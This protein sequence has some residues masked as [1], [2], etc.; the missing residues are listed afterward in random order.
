MRRLERI[1]AILL[2][3]ILMGAAL[4]VPESRVFADAQQSAPQNFDVSQ[5][6]GIYD[7]GHDPDEGYYVGLCWEPP[8][9]WSEVPDTSN[10]YSVWTS[11]D[12]VNYSWCLDVPGNQTSVRIYEHG[13][14]KLE[15][16][17]IYY[18]YVTAKHIHRDPVTGEETTNESGPSNI[19]LF[20]TKLDIEAA[21]SAPDSITIKWN[22]VFLGTSRIDYDIYISE[23]KD[24]NQTVP[25]NV[26]QDNIG[27]DKPVK[28]VQG[29]NKLM[30][31]RSGLRGGTIY[32]I[33]IKP[34]VSD[35]RVR[36]LDETEIVCGSTYIVARILRISDEF[37]RIEWNPVTNAVMGEGE[38]VSY[39]I[40]R[41]D[42]SQ[43]E[44]PI[45]DTLGQTRD[46]KIP[47]RVTR[48]S[49]YYRIV[50]HV[51]TQTGTV[52]EVKSDRILAVESEIPAVPPVPDL[53]DRISGDPSYDY[54][55]SLLPTEATVAWLAPETPDGGLD[56]GIVYDMWF[57]VAPEELE[58]SGAAP[59]ESDYTVPVT[60]YIKESAGS[61]NIVGY[62]YTF[63]NLVPNTS[64]YL[65]IIAKK[66]YTTVDQDG[67]IIQQYLASEPAYRVI[68]TPISEDVSKPIAPSKPPFSIYKENGEDQVGTDNVI[69]TWKNDWYEYWDTSDPA[70]PEWV[71]VEDPDDIQGTVPSDVYRH[72]VYGPDITFQV[73]CVEYSDTIDFEQLKNMPMRATGIQNPADQV[74]LKYTITG[75]EPNTAYI[76]WLKAAR[77]AD[78]VSD[79][80]DPLLVVTVAE[81]PASEEKPIVPT[82]TYSQGWDTYVE[83]W[84]T[85]RENYRY[86]IKYSTEDRFD[87]A[88]STV[89]VE[90]EDLI[91]VNTYKI[92]DLTPN[93]VY[94][95]WI[96]AETAGSQGNQSDWS[97]S[98]IVKTLAYVPPDAPKGFGVKNA[99][100]SVGKNHIAFE[101]SVE[102][103]LEYILVISNNA[104]FTDSTEYEVK[105]ASE[106]KVEGLMSNHRYYAKLYSY[107][108]AKGVRSDGYAGV[109]AVDTLKSTDEYDADINIAEPVS[110]VFAEQSTLNNVMN[111]SIT[112]ANADK[113]IEHI[114]KRKLI[115]Y[116]IDLTSS[117][118]RIKSREVKIAHHVFTALA[119]GRENLI[120]DTGE[121]KITT[122]PG[123]FD[124][125]TIKMRLADTGSADIRINIQDVPVDGL[126][127]S[128]NMSYKTKIISLD[129]STIA[130]GAEASVP[131][132]AK[133]LRIEMAYTVAET[134]AGGKIYAF[135]YDDFDFVWVK[136]DTTVLVDDYT[137]KGKAIFEIEKPGKITLMRVGGRVFG[138]VPDTQV[139]NAIQKVTLKYGLG[140]VEGGIF[141]P[142]D[143]ITV[144]EAVGMMLDVCNYK[145]TGNGFDAA[146]KAGITRYVE[147]SNPDRYCTRQEVI[148]MIARVYEIK[149][150]KKAESS[151]PLSGYT[152]SYRVNRNVL[153]IICFAVEKG[154]AI[155]RTQTQLAP[156]QSVSRGDVI[157][158]I[159][160]M[161]AAAGEI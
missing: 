42:L 4:P 78:L 82:F 40:R 128:G 117:S 97:E 118:S 80:S 151:I 140:S 57:A 98:Y 10:Y 61:N 13:T 18:S 36:H 23:S 8:A 141:R 135:V 126:N 91:G 132:F 108:P 84:W 28:P 146:A 87:S 83:L 32:Y 77:T 68:T 142:A 6:D 152:D 93:T 16:G 161:L 107:N 71:Y 95:F 125:G 52:I 148:T 24:F 37:W 122:R 54:T 60:D 129:V 41:G 62:K 90:P 31:T 138:D 7:I 65:K 160:R 102:P 73:G 74:D 50:A 114:K 145:R 150:G 143:G 119:E 20:M 105:T 46:T 109:M 81:P 45:E 21:T 121:C 130:L 11:S 35:P 136:K 115:D 112:S 104:D 27:P 155:G 106:Y 64:Y 159:E 101:W 12:G 3:L 59:V 144:K 133:P 58:G 17:K 38:E 139:K 120:I 5:T 154:I 14:Q 72:I 96:Q 103:G 79:P 51:D 66:M 30:Y 100:G 22:D 25:L 149:T 69:I 153:P 88:S 44:N 55:N 111:Y 70:N 113:F 147:I 26:R 116:R 63:R 1:K 124:T 53:R 134:D 2:V 49:Y 123:T 48:E 85:V 47:V 29:E 75:L 34:L 33:K 94:Y 15:P 39:Y 19:I 158:M 131:K 9:G 157:M 110:D 92:G 76:I 43:G 67:L 89:T 56:T 137:G 127:V 156:D 99:P 86:N